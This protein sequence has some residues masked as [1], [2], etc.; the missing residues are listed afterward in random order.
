MAHRS[1]ADV[2]AV[3]PAMTKKTISQPTLPD[4]MPLI[5]NYAPPPAEVITIA[6]HDEV[7]QAQ[8][9][10]PDITATVASLQNHNIH[11]YDYF[12]KMVSAHPIPNQKT[13]TIVECF[14]NNIVLTHGS[15]LVLLSDAS[16]A[17][18][19]V[20]TIDSLDAPGRP[21]TIS[22]TRLK[23]FI[24]RPVKEAFKLEASGPHHGDH[25]DETTMQIKFT[26]SSS[27]P[28]HHSPIANTLPT[29]QH[30]ITHLP[31]LHTFG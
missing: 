8:A 17:T 6:S 7:L 5:A 31:G 11:P 20:V 22:M 2:N 14:V 18:E 16:H 30:P 13:S 1:R 26:P 12:T 29:F 21:Q 24:P 3:T 23:P 25:V 27:F 9:A 10:D 28:L 4:S 19:N 15:L